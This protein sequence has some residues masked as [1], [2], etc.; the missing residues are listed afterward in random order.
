MEGRL[1][2]LR[3]GTAG[4][5]ACTCKHTEGKAGEREEGVHM[6]KVCR[7]CEG[8]F[9]HVRGMSIIKAF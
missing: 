5:C 8:V 7:Q 9:L 2:S 6:E 1:L 4:V 3:D